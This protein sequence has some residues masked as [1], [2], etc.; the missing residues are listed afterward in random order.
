MIKRCSQW[1][2]FQDFWVNLELRFTWTKCEPHSAKICEG[3]KMLDWG[4]E[5][6]SLALRALVPMSNSHQHIWR[7]ACK[8]LLSKV[9][10]RERVGYGEPTYTPLEPTL[11]PTLH[12]S[13]IHG[14]DCLPKNKFAFLHG[15][16]LV[17]ARGPW[18]L[19][20]KKEFNNQPMHS[21]L[22]WKWREN[23]YW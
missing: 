12:L 13:S 14:N 18:G 17:G 21:P 9:I 20:K 15:L 19:S 2:Y 8:M 11:R 10:L 16:L 6:T 4:I 23:K 22:N 1:T 5:P 3:M 7:F